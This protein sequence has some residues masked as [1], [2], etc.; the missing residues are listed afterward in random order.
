[1]CLL[2]PSDYLI[3]FNLF[4]YTHLYTGA[5]KTESH[6]QVKTNP[7]SREAMGQFT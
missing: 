3:L 6:Y 1:M 2:T 7:R 4:Y 5:A